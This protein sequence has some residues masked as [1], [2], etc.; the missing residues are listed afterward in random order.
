M[1][2]A[3][4]LVV[5]PGHSRAY[6]QATIEISRH[7]SGTPKWGVVATIKAASHDI[8]N[9]VAHH[10]EL[11]AHRIHIF[12]DDDAPG[13]RAA[14]EAHPR[15]N[16]ILCD[17]DY[18]AGRGERPDK[19]Q[20]RQTRNA[21][22]AYR[23][24]PGVAWL[25]HIDVDEFL[26]PRT[27]IHEQLAAL[28]DDIDVARVRPIEALAAFEAPQATSEPGQWFKAHTRQQRARRIQTAEIYPNFGLH[29]NGGFLSHVAGKIFVRTGIEKVNFR[30]HNA[31]IHG[32]QLDREAELPGTDLCHLH[33]PDWAHWQ[34]LYRYRLERGSYRPDLK[35]MPSPDGAGLNMN[36]LF[37]M[38]EAEGGEDALRAFYD[39]VCTATPDLMARLDARGLL[40]HIDLDLGRKR[41]VHFPDL[42]E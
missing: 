39:E 3:L 9:F 5:S 1:Q 20:S 13:A 19:H 38:L 28:P 8:L 24:R 22:R 17:A 2:S 6:E 31:F 33:A 16:V 21:T 25:A 42:S 15:V 40:R 12:L 36:A 37:S 32:V 41:M 27:P 34:K 10:L 23:R 7:M 14:L 29:L 4:A 30:I 18:W 11:G 35:P 26:W